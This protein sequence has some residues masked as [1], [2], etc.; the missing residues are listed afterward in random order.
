MKNTG[1]FRKN[2]ITLVPWC[3]IATIKDYKKK[4]QMGKIRWRLF[5][6]L[7]EAQTTGLPRRRVPAEMAARWRCWWNRFGDLDRHGWTVDTC[8]AYLG[9]KQSYHV[10][11]V[12]D[13]ISD[14]ICQVSGI[15]CP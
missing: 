14:V 12:R 13:Y 11:Y 8:E 3:L 10:L 1:L 2:L 15:R 5:L 6:Q 7:S 4:K 9:K